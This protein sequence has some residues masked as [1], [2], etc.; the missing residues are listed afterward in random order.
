ML[1]KE[2]NISKK[3]ISSLVDTLPDF[4]KTFD[5]AS[6]CL[7]NPLPKAK[8][9]IGSTKSKDNLTAHYYKD[10]IDY[11]YRRMFVV[12]IWKQQ[13]LHTFHQKV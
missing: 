1:E 9:E 8:I 7:Q 5:N 6:K 3:E 13:I 4:L 11:P 2:L 12:Q 10:I